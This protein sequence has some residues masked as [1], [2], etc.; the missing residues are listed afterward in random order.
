[1]RKQHLPQHL[2]AVI[3]HRR[4]GFVAAR[5]DPKNDHISAAESVLI[6]SIIQIL[7]ESAGMVAIGRP[8]RLQERRLTRR[9]GRKAMAEQ[10]W[11]FPAPYSIKLGSTRPGWSGSA[12][13]AARW[14]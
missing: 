9:L 14:R 7:A 4:G 5:F 13:A 6:I 1:L 3:D 2:T 8:A 10:L 11:R 12:H